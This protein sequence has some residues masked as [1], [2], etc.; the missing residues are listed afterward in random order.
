MYF[1]H[2]VANQHTTTQWWQSITCNLN[3]N[4]EQSQLTFINVLKQICTLKFMSYSHLLSIISN[5]CK[6]IILWFAPAITMIARH[7][8]VMMHTHDWNVLILPYQSS[9]IYNVTGYIRNTIAES[10]YEND[11]LMMLETFLLEWQLNL[12]LH[13]G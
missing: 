11:P 1:S 12:S 7:L 8:K 2:Y 4:L 13:G 6:L 10:Q 9:V 3:Q 5:S